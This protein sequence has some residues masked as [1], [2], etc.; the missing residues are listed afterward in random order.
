M[1]TV[2]AFGTLVKPLQAEFGWSR[3]EMSFALTITNITIVF[4]AP[5]LGYLVDRSGVRRLL[6]PSIALMG[7]AVASMTF[8][9]GNIWHFYG[10]FFAIT[11]L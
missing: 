1:F 6:L 2:F 10:V 8:L 3:A 7:F 5:M 9:Q 4:G 11:L